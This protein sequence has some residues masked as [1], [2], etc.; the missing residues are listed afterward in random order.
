[1]MQGQR[2]EPP[3]PFCK[4]YSRTNKEQQ[5]NEASG[6]AVLQPAPAA[7]PTSGAAQAGAIPAASGAANV[8]AMRCTGNK[9]PKVPHRAPPPEAPAM[10]TALKERQLANEHSTTPLTDDQGAQTKR[11]MIALLAACTLIAIL[12]I[13][14]LLL[15]LFRETWYHNAFPTRSDLGINATV[16]RKQGLSKRRIL[17]DNKENSTD[18][19]NLHSLTYDGYEVEPTIDGVDETTGT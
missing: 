7:A 12:V 18:E 14:Y 13:V 10:P 6:R 9:A 17:K 15:V 4:L 19:D 5:L 1:M 2:K 11:L 8:A 16:T 3:P